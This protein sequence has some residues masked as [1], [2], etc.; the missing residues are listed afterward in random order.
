MVITG[1]A[2][3]GKTAFLEHLEGQ[4]AEHHQAAFE[5]Q[6]AN[7]AA[8]SEAGRRFMLNHDGSQD[9]EAKDNGSVLAEFFAPYGGPDALAWPGDESPGH[10]D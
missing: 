9:E 2:G 4:A 10:R 6:R 8:F 5:E 7:G 1:N 3:D